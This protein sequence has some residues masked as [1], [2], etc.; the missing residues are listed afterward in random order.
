MRYTLIAMTNPSQAP[1]SLARLKRRLQRAG[2]RQQDVAEAAGI[3]TVHVCNV[4]AGRDTSRK[5]VTTAK[6]LLAEHQHGP[7]KLA[8]PA[9]QADVLESAAA[10]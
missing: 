6:R 8:A 7:E 4:L 3:S 5:V 2:I 1:G 9:E 10:L